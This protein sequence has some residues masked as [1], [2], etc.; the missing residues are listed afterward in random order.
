MNILQEFPRNYESSAYQ[1]FTSYKCR[2]YLVG[3]YIS[4][5]MCQLKFLCDLT[6]QE[7][8]NHKKETK[9]LRL[10]T[11]RFTTQV[12]H[13]HQFTAIF[14]FFAVSTKMADLTFLPM[15]CIWTDVSILSYVKMLSYSKYSI[16]DICGQ[17]LN[18]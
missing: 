17:H 6:S 13:R 8:I 16:P 14:E 15:L 18:N 3:F 4:T 7:S 10:T 2:I 5:F 11:L 9:V 1:I 12:P